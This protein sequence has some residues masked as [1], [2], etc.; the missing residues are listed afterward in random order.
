[1]RRVLV[2][3]I[4][5][6]LGNGCATHKSR[7]RAVLGSAIVAGA[8]GVSL[9]IAGLEFGLAALAPSGGC[10][11]QGDCDTSGMV[12][13]ARVL[14]IVGGALVVLGLTTLIVV[15]SIDPPSAEK[16]VSDWKEAERRRESAW[17]LTQ[18]AAH[19]ARGGDCA[20][21]IERGRF[22][23]E[24]D[25]NFHARVFVHDVAIEKCLSKQ[26]IFFA[27]LPPPPSPAAPRSGP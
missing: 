22:V 2:A 3:V 18:Q 16:P 24:L 26:G 15:K 12:H 5:A 14:A 6:V 23:L 10:A 19:A 20:T 13:Q 21:V 27:P 7:R 1:M 4:V 17:I 25:P 11:Q 9:S 8:G